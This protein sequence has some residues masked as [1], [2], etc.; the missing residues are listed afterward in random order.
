VKRPLKKAAMVGAADHPFGER[1]RR[2]PAPFAPGAR[3]SSGAAS[4]PNRVDALIKLNSLRELGVLTQEQHDSEYARLTEG[5]TDQEDVRMQLGPVQ[6]LVIPFAEGAF[7]VLILDE[8][9]R[10]REHDAIRMLDL[11]FVAKDEMGNIAQLKR[12]DLTV[13]EA[14][15]FGSLV[16]A[17]FSLGDDGEEGGPT[18]G[19]V[20]DAFT[21][22]EGL[23][24]DAP[25]TWFLGDTIPA[26]VAA[27]IALVEH[28]W[29]IA[30]RGAIQAAGGRDLVD[31][32]LHPEDLIAVGVAGA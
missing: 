22:Q 11:L 28:R 18:V 29:A 14:A 2:G 24:R 32:W 8:L 19:Q 23:L 20:D 26:G 21:D 15:T 10:L 31:R 7:D 30:L 16:A 13:Q 6:L 25:E 17:L 5:D 4:K 12:S 27:A 3:E 1:D 9:R